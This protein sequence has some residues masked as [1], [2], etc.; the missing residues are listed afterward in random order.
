MIAMLIQTK[1]ML[2]STTLLKNELFEG[3]VKGP[4]LTPVRTTKAYLIPSGI[5]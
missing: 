3:S 4:I 5:C 1:K 2:P